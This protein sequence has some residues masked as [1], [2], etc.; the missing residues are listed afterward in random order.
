V[1]MFGLAVAK[2]PVINR[3]AENQPIDLRHATIESCNLS[4]G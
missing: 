4:V 2:K 3:A 1:A